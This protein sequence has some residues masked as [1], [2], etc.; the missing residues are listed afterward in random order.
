MRICILQVFL[1]ATLWRHADAVFD[2]EAYKTDWQVVNVG[3]YR[4]VVDDGQASLVVLSDLDENSMLSWINRKD[5]N[6]EYR[7]KL[8]FRADDIMVLEEGGRV[9]LRHAESGQVSLFDT[10][11]GFQLDDKVALFRSSCTPELSGF[12]LKADVLKFHSLNPDIESAEI[13]LPKGFREIKYLSIGVEGEMSVL[14]ASEKSIYHYVEFRRGVPATQWARDE[15]LANIVAYTYLSETEDSKLV[16]DEWN[17][18]ESM[19]LVGGYLRRLRRNLGRLKTFILTNRKTPGTLLTEFLKDDEQS[20]LQSERRFGL[21]QKLLV[22][23]KYGDIVALNMRTGQRDWTFPTGF[24]DIVLLSVVQKGQKVH[25]FTK[26]GLSLILDLSEINSPTAKPGELELAIQ[27]IMRLGHSED[28][29][30]KT[31]FGDPELLVMDN[32]SNLNDKVIVDHSNEAVYA[33]MI[34]DSKP[35]PIWTVDVGADEEIVA[36]QGKEDTSISNVGIVLG[37]R[38]VLYKYLNPN[39]ASYVVANKKADTITVNIIDTITGAIIHRVTHEEH[40]NLLQPI[41]LV[42]GEHWIIYSYFSN[43]PIA[44]QRISVIEMYES[45]EPNTRYSNSS[46]IENSLMHTASPHFVSQSFIFSE[47]IKSMILSKTV[48]GIT[49]KA[50]LMELENGQL[51]YLPKFILNARRVAESQMSPDDRKE[52]MAAPYVG[53]IPVNDNFVLTHYRDIIT[54]K[55]S[56]LFS[57]PTNLE[58]TT[59]VCSLSHDLFCSRVA[60]SGQFDILSPTFEKGKLCA[61]IVALIILCYILGPIVVLKQIRSNWLVKEFSI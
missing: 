2:D 42:F 39:L 45:P 57:I 50:I 30:V 49:T 16:N 36:F 47:V 11:H 32:N 20:I 61:T 29:Y 8:E 23:T 31:A 7:Q 48:F 21:A 56:K 43:Q 1:W 46:A 15:S 37:N 17:V 38:T 34:K 60:P 6:V 5:G 13:A 19:N 59:F 9:A 10:Q 14:F 55:E 24:E 28:Y 22:A 26:R 41:N 44:E 53:T 35:Y 40:V 58:S 54:S 27:K 52:F 51:T 3:D 25:V 33:F 12:E 18:E 4:C